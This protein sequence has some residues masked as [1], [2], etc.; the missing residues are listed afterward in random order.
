MFKDCKQ[1]KKSKS[2]KNGSIKEKQLIHKQTKEK[3]IEHY[4]PSGEISSITSL[5][6]EGYGIDSGYYKTGELQ[7]TVDFE[8]NEPYGMYTYYYKSGEIHTQGLI[9]YGLE[10]GDWKSFYKNGNLKNHYRFFAGKLLEVSKTLNL[11]GDSLFKGN[12]LNGNGQVVSYHNNGQIET[13]KEYK[14]GLLHNVENMFSSTG[15]VL[16][17]GTFKNGNGNLKAYQDSTLDFIQI[18]EE[19]YPIDLK[20]PEEI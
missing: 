17:I 3:K 18:Y 5:D 7:H 1:L 8:N 15:K 13:L 9:N 2:Y 10:E 12:L 6:E 14:N 16:D 11:E 4:Y 19:G 20:Y